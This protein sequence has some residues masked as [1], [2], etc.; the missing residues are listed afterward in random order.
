VETIHQ[1]QQ[2]LNRRAWRDTLPRFALRPAA[3]DKVRYQRFAA[4]LKEQG[5]IKK[6]LPVSD[7]AVE[8]P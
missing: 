7:Y 1:K 5:L 8:L 4:F 3:F 2:E 6:V